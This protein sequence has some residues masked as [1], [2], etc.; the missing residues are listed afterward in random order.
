MIR[1]G[2]VEGVLEN[3]TETK[4]EM[5]GEKEQ[6]RIGKARDTF[7]SS[8]LEHPFD[9]AAP[10]FDEITQNSPLRTYRVKRMLETAWAVKR[11]P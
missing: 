10:P 7:H 11:R 9:T 8:I 5:V 4:K 1:K 6:G 3:L 2:I